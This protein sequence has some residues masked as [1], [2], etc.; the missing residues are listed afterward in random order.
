MLSECDAV[1]SLR[2]ASS[3]ECGTVS[4]RALKEEEAIAVAGI[5]PF[6]PEIGRSWLL[7]V[8]KTP[9]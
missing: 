8:S 3:V 9:S 6:G 2:T 7:L 1:G 4:F 5:V